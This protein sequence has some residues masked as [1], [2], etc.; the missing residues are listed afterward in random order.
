VLEAKAL[1]PFGDFQT[2]LGLS[3]A[4]WQVVD[5][6]DVEVLVE[7]TVGEGSF[8]ATTPSD[9]RYLPWMAYDIDPDY[10]AQA[11]KVAKERSIRARVQCKDSFQLDETVLR[12]D[13]AG[14]TV[15]AIGNPP[16]VTNAAQGA[17]PASNLPPK[18]NR[19]GLRGLDAM[20]GKANFDIAE[21]ILLAVLAALSSAAEVR[22]AFL[23]KR[24]VAVKMAKDVLGTPGLLSATFS[25]IEAQKWFG[26][27]VEA[28]LFQLTFQPTSTVST[29]RL[30]IADTLGGP[31]A[32]TAGL[33]DGVFVGDLAR[34]A[35]ASA[36]EARDDDR[37]VWR[38][39]VKHDLSK[40][41]ELQSTDSGLINGFGEKVDIE[42]EILCP[43]FKS[44]DIANGRPSRRWFPLYQHDLS[45]PLL[46]LTQ[47]WPKLA[48]YLW[49]HRPRFAARGSSIY[50]GKP[51]FMLFGVGSYTLAPFK[52]AISGFYKEP[53]FTLLRPDEAGRPPLVDDTCYILPFDN[54]YE[55]KIMVEYLNSTRV[56]D[57]LLSVA[58]IT[59][60]RP[61]TKEILGRIAS[62]A[63]N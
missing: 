19:F 21:A 1:D 13:V 17:L 37:L 12:K 55:A 45:G 7:P 22:F 61:F 63:G 30:L 51:D 32:T 33:I 18:F 9:Y 47:R 60:K 27:S 23:V 26:A 59:A 44:S 24:S 56:Q 29:D 43:F 35:A 42:D 41:L 4:I 8:L 39:G 28:G 14:K 52:V 62:H 40:V 58:D 3:A 11:R 16:W 54:E 2:P 48:S 10:V 31:F 5:M 53:C 46:D 38:Q 57:F 15:L 25:R 50:R 6:S 49:T 36:V 20:T 34:Y